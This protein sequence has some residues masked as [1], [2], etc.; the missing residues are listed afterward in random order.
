MA[1]GEPGCTDTSSLCLWGLG[2]SLCLSFPRRVRELGELTS[3]SPPHPELGRGSVFGNI[4]G[5]GQVTK[6]GPRGGAGG[7]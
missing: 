7:S 6:R 5:S 2:P 1:V 4:E 3:K